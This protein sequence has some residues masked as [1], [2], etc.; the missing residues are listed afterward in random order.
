[1]FEQVIGYVVGIL[2]S[3][4]V[5]LLVLLWFFLKNPEK[6]EKWASMFLK[7]GAYVNKKAEK[8]YMA[9]NI[10]ASISEKR[11]KLGLGGDV[12]EYG[13]KIEW[14]DEETA[15]TD[16]KENKLLVMMKPFRSQSRN[17]A[18]IVSLYVPQAVLPKA[19]SYVD[20]DLMKSIDYTLCKSMLE[21]NPTALQCYTNREI[22]EM[23]DESKEFLKKITPIHSI[24]RLTRLIIPEF[25]N[26]NKLFPTEPNP[27]VYEETVRFV[28]EIYKFETCSSPVEGSGL[29]IFSGK[30]IKMAIVP[31]GKQEKLWLSGITTHL[32]F[33]ENLL[34][35]GITHFFIVSA[36]GS[37]YP[38]QL[39]DSACKKFDLSLVFSEE[40]QGMFRG[41]ERKMFC[42]LCSKETLG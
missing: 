3:S 42:A 1:L 28:E 15:E 33:I 29:G 11:K 37:S 39:V 25:Q 34:A 38:K 17:L 9:T 21:D 18:S 20:Q 23:S 31:I 24:G 30:H 22:E 12:F 16:L 41:E 8:M 6:V 40:H 4:F 14:T 19:R 26:L 7:L 27:E 13:I 36:R 35:K 10:Q 32:K 2:S 5:T